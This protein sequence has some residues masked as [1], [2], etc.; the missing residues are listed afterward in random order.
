MAF[1]FKEVVGPL[2]LFLSPQKRDIPNIYQDE[3]IG[4]L[5]ESF[6]AIN[7]VCADD[8]K[9]LP[10]PASRDYLST[11]ISTYIEQEQ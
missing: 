6:R 11:L 9:S 7:S 1:Q 2:F 5:L 8:P 4:T 3:G 10:K